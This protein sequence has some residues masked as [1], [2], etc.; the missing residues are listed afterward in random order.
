MLTPRHPVIL[1]VMAM[2]LLVGGCNKSGTNPRGV[3]KP[4][5]S[6]KQQGSR[7]RPPRSSTKRKSRSSFATGYQP[8]HQGIY[9]PETMKII[10][11]IDDSVTFGPT[12]VIWLL[13]RSRSSSPLIDN[14]T[15][16]L[17]DYYLDPR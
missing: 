14:V 8:T 5:T 6:K 3:N 15:G 10:S 11:L 12:L 4:G 7:N 16:H 13:D 17:S 2:L 1:A 9:L